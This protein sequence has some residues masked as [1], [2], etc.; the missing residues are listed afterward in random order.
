LEE[1][2]N[3]WS[4]LPKKFITYPEVLAKAGYSIG[5]TGKAW[6]PGR[7]SAGGRDANPAG[8][9]F[10]KRKLKPSF[11]WMR[12]TD[13][14]AN[15]DD[16]LGQV[17]E[18]QPFC[19][20]LGTSEPHRGYELGSGKRTG[21]DPSKVIVPGIFPTIQSFG[22]ISSIIMLKLNTLIKWSPGPS[23]HLIGLVN[24]TIP[25][26]WSPVIMACPFQEL[27]RVF[28]M[29]ALMFPLPSVGLKGFENP[30]GFLMHW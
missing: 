9:E 27:K 7:L 19:F 14:A 8:M 21:K 5:F 2:G 16:F 30:D 15:F 26:S 4:T 28:T 3:L 22:M 13:Y 25:S 29:L 23:A 17:K 10:Q 6:S 12:N 18:D 24:L 11:K 1:A 20:W